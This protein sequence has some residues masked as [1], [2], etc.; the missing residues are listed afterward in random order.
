[1][2]RMFQGKM[3]SSSGSAEGL[4]KDLSEWISF[5]F[6]RRCLTVFAVGKGSSAGSRFAVRCLDSCGFKA[7][8]P[9]PTESLFAG[10]AAVGHSHFDHRRFRGKRKGS[11]QKV[12]CKTCSTNIVEGA[13]HS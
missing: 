3:A 8:S 7:V 5:S 13:G 1:M 9:A 11:A 2:P 4:R 10:W 6:E 12:F